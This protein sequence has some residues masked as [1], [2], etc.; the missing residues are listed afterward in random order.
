MGNQGRGKKFDGVHCINCNST[1]LEFRRWDT[2][3]RDC[4]RLQDVELLDPIIACETCNY[5]WHRDDQEC[6]NCM[7]NW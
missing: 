6:P 7:K 3:C 4:H 2:S 1:N 5:I